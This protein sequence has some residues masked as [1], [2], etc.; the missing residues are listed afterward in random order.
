[1]ADVKEERIYIK[2]CLKLSKVEMKAYK[3]LKESVGDSTLGLT[4]T[5]ERFKR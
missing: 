2:L 4:Q 5:C 3:M 1:M